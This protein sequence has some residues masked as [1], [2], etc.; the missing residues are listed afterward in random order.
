MYVNTTNNQLNLSSGAVSIA[1]LKAGGKSLQDDCTKKGPIKTGDVA[2][3]GPG[4]IPCKHIFHT[5][6]PTYDGK[7]SEKV[8][9]II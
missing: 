3:T 2:V 1:L 8:T 5:V 6:M 7:T 9:S 4:Q